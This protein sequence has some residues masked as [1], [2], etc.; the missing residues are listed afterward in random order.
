MPANGPREGVEHRLRGAVGQSLVREFPPSLQRFLAFE[1]VSAVD[2]VVGLLHEGD[3]GDDIGLERCG[4]QQPCRQ[5]LGRGEPPYRLELCRVPPAGFRFVDADAV[6]DTFPHARPP[7]LLSST[8]AA[9]ARKRGLVRAFGG[10]C[11]FTTPMYWA[12]TAESRTDASVSRSA[13]H[14]CTR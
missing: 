6:E 3:Q 12:F 14:F 11:M 7:Q 13:T 4:Q 9:R 2:A 5:V 10:S 8:R 1:A